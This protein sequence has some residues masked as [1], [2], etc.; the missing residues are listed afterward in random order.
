[1]PRYDAPVPLMQ[2]ERDNPLMSRY[3]REVGLPGKRLA[4]RC[5]ISHS[6]L[7]MARKRNVGADNA[8]KISRG[9][10]SILGLSE[11]DRLSLKAEIM[12][13]PGDL[14]RAYLGDA[15]KAARLL[16][17]PEVTASEILDEGKSVAHH[18]GT[19]ALN[20]LRELGAPDRVV[21]SV[22]RRLVPPP[23][24]PR[25]LITHTLH[26]SEMIEQRKRTRDSLRLGKPK[27]HEAVQ[28]SG[29]KIGEIHA[30][31]GVGKE[32]IRRALYGRLGGR[33]SARAI[34]AVLQETAGLS[35]AETRAVENELMR[36]P[37]DAS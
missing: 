32:T 17:V 26:G 5:G 15:R 33:R 19:R 20:R 13:H 6:Q 35:D 25:G 8:E 2:P 29:L 31:A 23:T 28:R 14:V 4:E 22:D 24:R 36:P 21:E 12:G 34:A 11:E 30:R 37:T 3:F 18:N 9:M 1:M 16:D 10:A 7:Y 27:V